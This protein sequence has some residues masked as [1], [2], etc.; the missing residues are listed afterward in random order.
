M[1]LL[2]SCGLSLLLIARARLPRIETR[3][4]STAGVHLGQNTQ[5]HV[6]FEA[7]GTALFVLVV[8]C[9]AT[10]ALLSSSISHDVAA[11]GRALLACALGPLTALMWRDALEQPP[12]GTAIGVVSVLLLVSG[13]TGHALALQAHPASAVVVACA[14]AFAVITS[15]VLAGHTW[16]RAQRAASALQRARHHTEMAA[17]LCMC[18]G[19]LSAAI[20]LVPGAGSSSLWAM[21][22]AVAVSAA[23][24][25]R[26]AAVAPTRRDLVVV[27]MASVVGLVALPISSA[28]LVVTATAIAVTATAG[29]STVRSVVTT[30]PVQPPATPLAVLAV[31]AG[32]F[33]GHHAAG[34]TARHAPGR[35]RCASRDRTART[36]A[37]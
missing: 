15:G 31:Q 18:G 14:L 20:E 9:V 6:L 29:L 33:G 21:C 17:A 13:L 35:A 26:T 19:A 32:P 2:A 10:G 1:L 34:A 27:A 11:D 25:A 23:V 28:I 4:G 7:L 24:S 3:L 22:A 16:R 30:P 36:I 12:A 5:S 37:R 8:L